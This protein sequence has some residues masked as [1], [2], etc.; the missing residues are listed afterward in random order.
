MNTRLP[1]KLVMEFIG[2]FALCF[3]GIMAIN[4]LGASGRLG[5][6]GIALAHGLILGIMISAAMQT[7]GGHFNPAVTFG[8]LVTGKMKPRE[9]IAYII[10]QLLG[11]IVASVAVWGIYG[12][13]T[14][15]LK[16]VAGGTPDLAPG[17]LPLAGVLTEIILTFFLVFAV[18]GTAADPRA[19]NVGVFA[20]GLTVAADILAGVPVTGASMNPAR[21]FGPT[22][23]GGFA[24]PALWANHWI[25]WVGPLIGGALAACIYY[26]ILWPRDERK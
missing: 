15:G 20:I 12:C 14:E 11:S 24:N 8:F 21:S 23:I 1:A 9:G 2:T 4:Q 17:I 7:S 18:W 13:T 5:L 19:H 3:V 26:S 16:V 25:Y 10:A 22:L 6:V